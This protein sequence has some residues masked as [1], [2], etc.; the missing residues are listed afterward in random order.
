[1]PETNKELIQLLKDRGVLKS[2]RI[3]EAMRKTPREHFVPKEYL[4][5]A[6]GN[7][8]LSIGE[9]QTISQPLTVV[10]M[11]EILDVKT[12][13][14]V[15]EIG[16]GSGWQT[17]MLSHLVG[18]TGQV[19][20]FEIKPGVAEFGAR[21]ITDLQNISLLPES[22]TPKFTKFAPFDRIISGAAFGKIP[23]D[24]KKSLKDGGILVSPT[25]QNDIRVI[26]K[27]GD[28][29]DESTIPGFVF[30]PIR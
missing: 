11:L 14:K 15:L 3:E 6:Y 20:A 29:F 22:Y 8:P 17:A 23:Q 19:L 10:F 13:H 2:Q 7:Y 4:N 24:L 9:G 27:C 21:N 26:K 16:Y 5:E 30:V 28:S 25:A 1:V 18:K 12:G